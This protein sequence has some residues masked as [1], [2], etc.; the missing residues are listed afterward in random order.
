MGFVQLE[1]KARPNVDCVTIAKGNP[2]GAPRRGRKLERPVAR[3][4]LSMTAVL[5]ISGFA[6]AQNALPMA[7]KKKAAKAAK[8]VTHPAASHS[9][10]A[11]RRE[12]VFPQ[13]DEWTGPAHTWTNKQHHG[14]QR[15]VF[16]P[17]NLCR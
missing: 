2:H 17:D 10:D 8:R 9:G 7:K 12:D 11:E 15:L 4:L 5:T 14:L 6:A 3:C 16:G 1:S 13:F